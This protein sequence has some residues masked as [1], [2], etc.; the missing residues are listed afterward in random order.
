MAG[1]GFHLLCTYIIARTCTQFCQE[2]EWIKHTLKTCQLYKVLHQYSN[3]LNVLETPYDTTLGL[4][5]KHK[6][7]AAKR[8]VFI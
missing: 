7:T 1:S 2:H 6:S 3:T 4:I 5:L 8:E